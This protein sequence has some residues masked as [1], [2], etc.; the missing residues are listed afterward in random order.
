MTHRI[1]VAAGRDN[2]LDL[3]ARWRGLA[4]RRLEY[5]TE[6][7][8]SGRWRRYYSERAFLEDIQQAKAAVALWRNLSMPQ[9]IPAKMPQ[10]IPAKMPHG[11]GIAPSAPIIAQAAP[12]IAPAAP[13]IV[14]ANA[15]VDLAVTTDDTTSDEMLPVQVSPPSD[16]KTAQA[17]ATEARYAL[18]RNM[19]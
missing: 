1:D 9:P 8:E 15:V 7:F 16:D 13:I 12:I 6:L 18:L 10:P 17:K 5:L 14:Q 3:G 19:L 2:G 4:E 11:E